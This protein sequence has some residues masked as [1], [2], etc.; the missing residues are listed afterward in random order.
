MIR[1]E[2]GRG[3]GL[4]AGVTQTGGW[5]VSVMPLMLPQCPSTDKES[6]QTHQHRQAKGCWLAS[7]KSIKNSCRQTLASSIRRATQRLSVCLP[8]FKYNIC[9]FMDCWNIES[10]LLG[11]TIRHLCLSYRL[12]VPV[13]LTDLC[14]IILG[15]TKIFFHYCWTGEGGE[16]I[17][18]W[19]NVRLRIVTASKG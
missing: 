5:W 7:I 11:F 1:L 6:L 13:T 4:G 16:W 10:K 9:H 15:E 14:S 17:T 8:T 12:M 2:A 3:G 18:Y 19:S